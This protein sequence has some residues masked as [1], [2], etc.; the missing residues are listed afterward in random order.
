MRILRLAGLARHSGSGRGAAANAGPSDG[1]RS[2][3]MT[4]LRAG[5]PQPGS[6][7]GRLVANG[8]IA[9]LLGPLCAGCR[10]PLSR[11]LASAVCDTCW[12]RIRPVR[13][14]YCQGCGDPLDTWR[15]GAAASTDTCGRCLT[16][17]SLVVARAV[18]EFDDELRNV[19]H[20][21]KYDGRRSIGR[22]L[23]R[24]MRQHQGA[25]VT[26]ADFV[27]PVP[28]HWRRRW[29]R[30]FNQAALIA[31]GLGR[32]VV[33]ALRRTRHTPSQTDLPAGRRYANVN[34]AFALRRGVRVAGRSVLLVDDVKTTGATLEACAMVLVEGGAREVRALTAARVSIRPLPSPRR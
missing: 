26:A 10:R 12:S 16:R 9:V 20:A 13:P 33:H 7:V 25:L 2:G 29:K 8:L 23:G 18:G 24:L 27:V 28:L 11:P 30:G 17:R 15:T 19:L 32:P 6:A 31:E 1:T 21:L 4:R 22:E 3:W 14:P 5:R 34:R